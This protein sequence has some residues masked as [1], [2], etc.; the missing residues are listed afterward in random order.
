ME[1]E[2][3]LWGL[4]VDKIKDIEDV[5]LIFKAMDFFMM[6]DA[7]YFNEVKHLF[8]DGDRKPIALTEATTGI[9]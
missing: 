6:E 4:D 5:K 7:P 3:K 8:C 9:S 1:N 2:I